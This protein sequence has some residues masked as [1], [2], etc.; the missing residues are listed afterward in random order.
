MYEVYQLQ[1]AGAADSASTIKDRAKDDGMYRMLRSWALLAKMSLMKNILTCIFKDFFLYLQSRSASTLDESG[2]LQ[3][4]LRT[5]TA[6]KSEDGLMMIA[7]NGQ[8]AVD[9]CKCWIS[10][11]R[12]CNDVSVFTQ[13]QTHL[14]FIKA[15]ADIAARFPNHKL[16]EAGTVLTT[17]S[18]VVA[19]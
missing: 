12:T 1:K 13:S 5:L 18:V 8:V 14:Q 11:T 15:L 6:M 2:R 17:K 19:R 3:T 9:G 4:T 10:V 7:F 16:Q